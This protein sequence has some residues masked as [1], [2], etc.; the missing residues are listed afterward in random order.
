MGYTSPPEMSILELKWFHVENL[1][2]EPIN[3]L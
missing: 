1:D 2:D 3:E